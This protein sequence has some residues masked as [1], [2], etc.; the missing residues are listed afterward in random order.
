[1]QAHLEMVCAISISK[2]GIGLC[3]KK[4]SEKCKDTSML[5]KLELDIP[6][7]VPY[8]MERMSAYHQKEI[9]RNNRAREFI[10]A[11]KLT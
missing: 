2:G 7:Y 10:V 8:R 3:R 4:I 6:I 1:M 11:W 9:G 5:T